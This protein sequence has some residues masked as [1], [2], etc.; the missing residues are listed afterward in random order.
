MHFSLSFFLSKHIA[1]V[2]LVKKEQIPRLEGFIIDGG[3]VDGG[4][5]ECYSS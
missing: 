3:L 1:I 5:G 2:N 4:E